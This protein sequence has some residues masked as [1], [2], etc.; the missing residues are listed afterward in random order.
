M[1]IQPQN[2]NLGS[3]VLTPRGFGG[4]KMASASP[5]NGRVVRTVFVISL[6]VGCLAAIVYGGVFLWQRS[7]NIKSE[8]LTKEIQQ[9][10]SQP[11]IDKALTQDIKATNEAIKVLKNL[12]ASHIVSESL[13]KLVEDQTLTK[14][15]WDSLTFKAPQLFSSTSA[16]GGGLASLALSGST[17][18]YLMAG[19]QL[20]AFEDLPEVKSVKLSQFGE[21]DSGVNFG[22]NIDL[23]P[24]NFFLKINY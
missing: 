24:D 8:N 1:D 20:R 3:P 23:S 21:S 5:T 4:S 14:V 2:T 17:Q 7:L 13:F 11:I 12:L 16:A 15:S 9:I 19:R 18:T 6:V 10:E 22:L